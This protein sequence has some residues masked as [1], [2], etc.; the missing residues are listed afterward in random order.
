MV[1]SLSSFSLD[2][3]TFLSV[4]FT[5]LISSSLFLL[6]NVISPIL[7]INNF[8]QFAFYWQLSN[9][10]SSRVSIFWLVTSP[11]LGGMCLVLVVSPLHLSQV[12]WPH[13]ASSTSVLITPDR[14][15]SNV[16]DSDIFR[17]FPR[18]YVVCYLVLFHL[19]CWGW[20]WFGLYLGLINYP[21]F[22]DTPLYTSSPDT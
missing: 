16:I 10:F 14:N 8:S 7:T 13:T 6:Y 1:L 4:L 19:V 3:K 5:S 18:F 15:I 21:L 9:L 22:A 2:C 11:E 20:D 12:Q 17:N